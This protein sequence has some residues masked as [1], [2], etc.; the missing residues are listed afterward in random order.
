V[1]IDTSP[2]KTFSR[3]V[4]EMRG[5]WAKKG[6]NYQELIRGRVGEESLIF[7]EIANRKA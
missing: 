5:L 2:L 7:P 3:I 4:P 1:K 6:E